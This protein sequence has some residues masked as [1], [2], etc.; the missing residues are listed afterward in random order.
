MLLCRYLDILNNLWIG[1]STFSFCMR[2]CKLYSYSSIRAFIITSEGSVI[3]LNN[4]GFKDS[5]EI[6]HSKYS[7]HK[8]ENWVQRKADCLI[9]IPQWA[10]AVSD[11]KQILIAKSN[12][13]TA[14][15]GRLPSREDC[16]SGYFAKI[17]GKLF[18]NLILWGWYKNTNVHLSLFNLASCFLTYDLLRTDP[19]DNLQN[20]KREL[21]RGI[22]INRNS[23]R[24]IW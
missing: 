3:E 18:R 17:F 7:L 12:L 21:G 9:K 14:P 4:F 11:W 2:P 6:I 5:S 15:R 10:L 24:T 20:L 1:G 22:Q 19:I 16:L 13:L 23:W 8:Q